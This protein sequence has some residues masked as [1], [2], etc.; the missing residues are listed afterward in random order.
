MGIS[1]RIVS[2]KIFIMSIYEQ[3]IS[4]KMSEQED[5][6]N[7][8]LFED[9]SQAMIHMVY[10]AERFFTNEDKTK[11]QVNDMVDIAYLKPLLSWWKNNYAAVIAAVE[12]NSSTFGFEKMDPIDKAIFLWGW[13]EFLIHKTPL[14]IIMNEMIEISKRYG[15]EWSPKLI[16]GIGHKVIQEL[17]V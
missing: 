2:R 9:V 7:F 5:P 17:E 3:L 16:N 1:S 11:A 10:M 8:Q 4:A 12:N 6:Y 14:K 15:D 13:V